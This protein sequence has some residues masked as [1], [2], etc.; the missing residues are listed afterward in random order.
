M[1]DPTSNRYGYL[2]GRL[3]SHLQALEVVTTGI[4]P[5]TSGVVFGK[6]AVA[7]ASPAV[8]LRLVDT[9]GGQWLRTLAG[10]DPDQ[11]AEHEQRIAG[12]VARIAAAPATEDLPNVQMAFLTG[13]HHQEF[14]DQRAE[15]QILTTVQVAELL[16]LGSPAAARVQLKRWGLE[17]CG[18]DSVTGEKLWRRR[19]VD[20][21]R[22]GRPGRGARTDLK[23]PQAK[24]GTGAP[25]SR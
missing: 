4:D 22:Q 18:T 20:E 19:E 6:F 17:P 23:R 3:F 15:G 10:R 16:G 13:Y 11:A 5:P 9:I 24:P 8:T 21:R 2:L 12:L 14:A 1:L 25:P 7:T